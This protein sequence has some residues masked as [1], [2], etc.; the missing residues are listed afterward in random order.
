MFKKKA[1]SGVPIFDI[2]LTR[3]NNEKELGLCDECGSPVELIVIGES[4]TA[5]FQR[6]L[7]H[8]C[9]EECMEIAEQRS[10]ETTKNIWCDSGFVKERNDHANISTMFENAS[11]EDFSD[12]IQ[13]YTNKYLVDTTKY[14]LLISSD[15]SG[16]G[17]SHLAVAILKRYLQKTSGLF[18]T[19][20][21]M[22]ADLL[23]YDSDTRSISYFKSIPVL[24]LDDLGVEK[25][26]N[27]RD[28]A[29][30]YGVIDHRLNNNLKT[31]I[32]TNLNVNQIISR[33]TQRVLSR[34]SCG[35]KIPMNGKDRRV[36]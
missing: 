18:I 24:V 11:V 21:E 27:E 9:T 16:V 15:Q 10:D 7:S 3:S 34:I 36:Q 13:T 22:M 28:L 2:G 33:Y 20:N 14:M 30:L 8:Y 35:Y 19:T 17:K 31:I 4:K 32:T 23:S 1:E 6:N 25:V 26:M 29:L 5:K 12:N